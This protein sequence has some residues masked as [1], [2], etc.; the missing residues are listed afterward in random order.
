MD[1]V[2]IVREEE[3]LAIG[4]FVLTIDKEDPQLLSSTCVEG[5][6][7]TGPTT[8]GVTKLNYRPSE[9]ISVLLLE[10]IPTP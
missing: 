1:G 2:M 9:D 7:R 5:I 8:F 6:K 10:T 4:R 3:L